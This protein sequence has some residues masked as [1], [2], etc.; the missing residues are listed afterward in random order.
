MIQMGDALSVE[1]HVLLL[2][3][4]ACELTKWVA[5]TNSYMFTFLV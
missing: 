2:V 1:L 5:P 3:F 4:S